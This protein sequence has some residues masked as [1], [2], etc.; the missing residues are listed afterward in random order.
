MHPRN[1]PT[2]CKGNCS[3]V[4]VNVYF[5]IAF[6]KARGSHECLKSTS[7]GTISC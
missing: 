6:N 5:S 7:D 2:N 1:R 3:S 4:E